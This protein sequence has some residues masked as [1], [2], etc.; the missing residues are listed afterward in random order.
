MKSRGGPDGVTDSGPLPMPRLGVRHPLSGGLAQVEPDPA[1]ILEPDR[2]GAPGLDDLLDDRTHLF[3]AVPL[4][5]RRL[6]LGAPSQGL[7]LPLQFLDPL[8][9]ALMVGLL[10]RGRLGLFLPIQAEVADKQVEPA[11]AVPV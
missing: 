2:G 6:V 7:E 11:V 10:I 9:E 3:L 4:R 8:A 5:F 1:V